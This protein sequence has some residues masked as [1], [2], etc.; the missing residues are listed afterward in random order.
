MV[1]SFQ[2]T[3]SFRSKK[4]LYARSLKF[5][6]RLHS[7]ASKIR[8]DQVTNVI[9]PPFLHLQSVSDKVRKTQSGHFIRVGNSSHLFFLQQCFLLLFAYI[10]IF[11][12]FPYRS[13]A[14]GSTL[15]RWEA[16]SPWEWALLAWVVVR[17][18]D[19]VYEVCSLPLCQS[20]S[21]LLFMKTTSCLKTTR[22]GDCVV[23]A[24]L[25]FEI[26]KKGKSTFVFSQKKLFTRKFLL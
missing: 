4:N 20:A 15:A 7:S 5:K 19:E 1:F 25:R 12:F 23:W 26:F 14:T 8:S 6:F 13:D 24:F 11:N 18:F 17:V 22:S 3:K 16:P 21:A 9:A 10:L 2:W